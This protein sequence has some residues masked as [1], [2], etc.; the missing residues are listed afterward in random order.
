[1]AGTNAEFAK[2]NENFRA[3][4][5]KVQKIKGYMEFIPTTRQASKWRM[6][7]GIA[8]KIVNNQIPESI[9]RVME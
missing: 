4:C 9:K 1:M 3:A 7:K 5:I 6:E 2:T 8:W